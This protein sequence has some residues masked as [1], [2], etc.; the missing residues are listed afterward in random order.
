MAAVSEDFSVIQKQNEIKT[1]IKPRGSS[2]LLFTPR[3]PRTH[4]PLVKPARPLDI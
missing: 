1:T 4:F 2:F 3:E